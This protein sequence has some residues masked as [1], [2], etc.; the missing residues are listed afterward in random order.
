MSVCLL[1]CLSVCLLVCPSVCLL[2]CP[3]VC[4][5][6]CLCVCLS[7]CSSPLTLTLTHSHSLILFNMAIIE[8]IRDVSKKRCDRRRSGGQL[9]SQGQEGGRLGGGYR[10]RFT[11]CGTTRCVVM[12]HIVLPH[13]ILSLFHHKFFIVLL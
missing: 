7:A 9:P 8:G 5:S 11:D 4:L 3:S 1:V 13:I 2:V 12:Q 10:G 6:V